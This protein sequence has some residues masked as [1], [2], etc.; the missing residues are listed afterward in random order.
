M[1]TFAATGI[2]F[3]APADSARAVSSV[4]TASLLVTLP[5]VAAVAGAIAL[6]RARAEARVLVWR[7]TLAALVLV[8]IG[9][10]LPLHWMAW[11]VPSALATPLVA[12]GR[13][14]VASTP[15]LHAGGASVITMIW[16]AYLL[17]ASFVAVPTM[18]ASLKMR[19]IARRA[20]V[21]DD[22]RWQL[23]LVEAKRSIGI[24]REIRL[25][26]T[27]EL[28]I[29]ATWGAFHPVVAIPITA[30]E[31]TDEQ[32]SIVLRHELAHVRSRDWLFTV[33]ARVACA[34]YWFHPGVWWVSRRLRDDCEHVSDDRVIASGV[35]RSDYAELLIGAADRF[36]GLEPALAL[37]RTRGLRGRLGAIL[38][39]DHSVVPLARGWFAFAALSTALVA[40][41]ISAVRLA[42]TRDVLTSLMRDSRWE[43]RAYAVLGLAERP[44]TLAVARAAAEADPN[45]RVRAW[46]RYALRE[47]TAAQLRAVLHQ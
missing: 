42:P 47:G 13:V 26:V 29:P 21:L 38:D 16:F 45:P 23:A 17:G 44:D 12:L 34:L 15:E 31:W 5:L 1:M 8:F 33:I 39:I 7:S 32:I 6:R 25:I 20:L 35:R 3:V 46:A 18:L 36:L 41:P 22:D 24:E 14:Q 37:S 30:I 10:Q 2:P 19:R 11:V 27:G 4:Y 43:S 28:G 40:G 9:R